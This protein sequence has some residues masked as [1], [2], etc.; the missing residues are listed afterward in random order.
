MVETRWTSGGQPVA[1]ASAVPLL[2]RPAEPDEFGAVADL[3]VAAYATFVDADADGYA[4]VLRDVAARAAAAEVLVAEEG[5]ELLGTITFVPDGGALGEIAE[6]GE[7]EFRMLAVAPAGQGRGV[8]TALMRHVLDETVRRGRTGVVCSSQP[9]MR[10]A[11][12][13]YE[14]L[15][16]RRDPERDWSPVPGVDLL[17]FAWHPLPDH[18]RRN[19]VSWDA[20]AANYVEA[21]RRNWAASE[22]S[23][24]T[25][26][27]PEAEVGALPPVDGMDVIELGCGTAYVSAWLGRRGARP[28]G[29]DLSAKQLETA[30]AMQEQHGVAFPLHH[31]SAEDVPLP[32]ASFDLAVSEYGASLWC[33]PDAWVA[34]AARLLR[35]GGLLVF[36][37]NSL[38]ATLCSPETGP[39]GERLVRDQR[40]LRAVTYPDDDAVEFHL[41][42]GEWMATMTRHGFAVEAL[43]ELYAPPGADPARFEWVTPEWARR[44]P[45]EELWRARKA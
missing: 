16:F 17:A 1:S 38:I 6:D 2:I 24:G 13:V 18:A 41:A 15:G 8:G 35:P 34:E 14:R 32:D 33:D 4:D 42:H 5:G 36:L 27:V 26:D 3:C 10:A 40:G 31:A 29:V 12:R 43:H 45:H 21:A 37:T 39:A 25:W 11:H 7:A 23:W 28:V 9:A 30:R 20:E 22:I 44:W 19:Q